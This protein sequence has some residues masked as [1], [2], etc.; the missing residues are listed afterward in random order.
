MIISKSV[1]IIIFLDFIDQLIDYPINCAS[2]NSYSFSGQN[3]QNK[4]D[5][6][7]HPDKTG[8]TCKKYMDLTC[9]EITHFS[10]I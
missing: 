10:E 6:V 9:M 4:K 7:S 3:I 2:L 1:M 5:E 8:I